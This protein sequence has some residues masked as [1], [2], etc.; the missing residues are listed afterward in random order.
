MDG[1]ETVDDILALLTDR[2]R[3]AMEA[4]LIGYKHSEIAVQLGVCRSAVSERLRRSRKRW[5]VYIAENVT[6][7]E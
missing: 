7:E 5:N 1:Y 2:Q 4:R 6:K 3:E